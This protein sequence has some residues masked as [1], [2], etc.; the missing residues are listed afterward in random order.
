MQSCVVVQGRRRPAFDVRVWL[1]RG[2]GWRTTGGG[3]AR[4]VLFPWADLTALSLSERRENEKQEV[5]A[6][7]GPACKGCGSFRGR[8]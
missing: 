6:G 7:G 1:L 4:T 5:M 3:T 8:C 2:H